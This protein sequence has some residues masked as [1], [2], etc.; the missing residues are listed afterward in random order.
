MKMLF[1]DHRLNEAFNTYSTYILIHS[2][3]IKYLELNTA[4]GK[5]YINIC[6]YYYRYAKYSLLVI[7]DKKRL[8]PF[9]F[10]GY[11]DFTI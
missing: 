8:R 7:V 2:K 5:C 6:C 3:Y 4:H 1:L 11:K 9:F 10:S